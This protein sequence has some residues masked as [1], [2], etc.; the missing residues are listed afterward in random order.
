MKRVYFIL[1]IAGTLFLNACN[2]KES[3]N[4]PGTLNTTGPKY[5]TYNYSG[6]TKE[7]V[8]GFHKRINEFL[9]EAIGPNTAIWNAI[10]ISISLKFR[11]TR[12]Y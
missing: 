12:A 5:E 8:Y 6:F 10:S 2:T 11:N 9:K 3:K 7:E 4:N 1:L